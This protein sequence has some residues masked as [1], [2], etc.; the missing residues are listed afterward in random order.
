MSDLNPKSGT[1][2]RNALNRQRGFRLTPGGTNTVRL[3]HFGHFNAS[4]H[5]SISPRITPPGHEVIEIMTGGA[6]FFGKPLRPETIYRRGTIFWHVAGEYTISRFPDGEPYQCLSI[7]FDVP[8]RGRDVSR[9]SQWPDS[10]DFDEFVSEAMRRSH[11]ETIDPGV[12]SEYLYQRIR[13]AAYLGTRQLRRETYPLALTRALAALP[14]ATSPGFSVKDLA[15][16]ARVSEAHLYALFRK[17]LGTSP[18]RHL[19]NYRLRL[20][21]TRLAGSDDSIKLIAEETGFENIESFYRAFHRVTGMPPG[22]YRDSQQNH[23]SLQP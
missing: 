15:A 21:R 4:G 20:A 11:D 14:G 8:G 9:V 18:H 13:W 23:S 7:H 19:L 10:F 3:I 12:W 6:V 22:E 5:R 16:C 2:G 1:N 17:H